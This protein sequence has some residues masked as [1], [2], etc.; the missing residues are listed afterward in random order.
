VRGDPSRLRQV[1]INLIG[2]AVK[3]TTTGEVVVRV[4]VDGEQAGGNTGLFRALPAVQLPGVDPTLPPVPPEATVHLRV[5]VADTGPGIPEE[6]QPRMFQ[7][8]SQA[9]SSTTRRFG[10]TGLGLAISRHL[11][12]L[13]GGRIG[14]VSAPGGTTFY[15]SMQLALP[16]TPADPAVVPDNLRELRILVVDD[17][18]TCRD[19]LVARLDSWGLKAE[20]VPEPAQALA[21]LHDAQLAEPPVSVVII[22]L[23]MPGIDGLQL[24]RT[25]REDPDLRAV[26]LIALTTLA[27][28]GAS[29]EAKRLGATACLTKP[30][31]SV[32]L[33][34][35]LLATVGI[36]RDPDD[37][38]QTAATLR[39]G[40]RVLVADDNLVNRRLALAQL[41]QLGIKAEAVANGKEAL[42]ALERAT[43]DLILM[44]GQMPELDGYLATAEIRRREGA[45]R[46][47]IVIAM[48]AD[49]L[50]GDRE[51][52]L[53][54]GMD[55]YLPKPVKI[56]D[57]RAMLTR[58]LPAG[59]PP[60]PHDP[61][62]E[63]PFADDSGS[64]RIRGGTEAI[65][66]PTTARYRKLIQESGE[67]DPAVI[68]DLLSQGGVALVATLGESLRQEAVTQIPA[69]EKAV[70]HDDGAAASAAAHRIKGAAWSLGL[71]GLASACLGLEHAL[72]VGMADTTRLCQE[73]VKAYERGQAALDAIVKGRS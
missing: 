66:R 33:L 8:F 43:Y 19:F 9:D 37:Q 10:G 26:H 29:Q 5:T 42:T 3:F 49:A 35:A 27:R 16:D 17:N 60:L 54:A 30:V 18:E 46:H 32:P 52:C 53:A 41:A 13:M 15:F 68:E 34:D 64:V 44:D 72:A 11:V 21:V 62:E 2:N 70:A 58:W 31:R 28:R 45:E 23:E 61:V 4:A 14:F 24:A 67:L 69:L 50:S 48:T 47:T 56:S 12:E 22:D 20:A 51:R 36:T 59:T 71:R 57:L 40:V 39:A 55:D 1:L 65:E 63:N 25:I 38:P 73:V 6:A 7:A